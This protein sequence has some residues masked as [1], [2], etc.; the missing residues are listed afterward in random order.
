[1]IQVVLAV[2]GN[3]IIAAQNDEFMKLTN[4]NEIRKRFESETRNFPRFIFS[5]VIMKNYPPGYFLEQTKYPEQIE[6][7]QRNVISIYSERL[8]IISPR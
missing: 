8:V 7:Y 1:M 3:D 5:K 4:E 6:N 2:Y